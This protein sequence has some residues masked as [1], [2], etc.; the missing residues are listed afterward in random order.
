M[1]KPMIYTVPCGDNAVSDRDLLVQDGAGA[2]KKVVTAGTFQGVANADKDGEDNVAMITKGLKKLPISAST[3]FNVGD[4]LGG[5]SSGVVTYASGTVL[6]RA[7]ET[8]S[9]TTSQLL[10]CEIDIYN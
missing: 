1:T 10:L 4:K 5:D 3:D 8:S 6:G 7:A 9:L 2:M